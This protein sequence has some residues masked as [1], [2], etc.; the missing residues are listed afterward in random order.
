MIY[1]RKKERFWGKK[2]QE[3]K[4]DQEGYSDVLDFLLKQITKYF[5]HE[6]RKKALKQL[7]LKKVLY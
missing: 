7:L 6:D 1:N 4:M 5:I 3:V 2:L